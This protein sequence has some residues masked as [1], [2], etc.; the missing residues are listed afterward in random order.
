MRG[1]KGTQL[2]VSQSI[3]ISITASEPATGRMEFAAEPGM[4]E[5]SAR[6]APLTQPAELVAAPPS[7]GVPSAL[8]PAVFR[9]AALTVLFSAAAAHEAWKLFSLTSPEIWVH[10]RTGLWI[11]ENRAVPHTGLFSRYSTLAWIDS[12]WLYDLRLGIAY[13]MFGLRAIP[14]SLI[15]VR[16]G[17]ALV[18][19]FV[20]RVGRA[21]FWNAVLL[22][23]VA[24]YVISELQPLPYVVSIIFFAIEL[25]WLMRT[26]QTGNAKR[27]LWLPLLFVLWANLHI[28]FVAGLI[29][30]G[31]FL[32]AL[33]VENGLR[34][35]HAGWISD[36]IVP[37]DLKRTAVIALL[38][39]LAT[40]VNP[41]GF[42]LIPSALKP[43]YS[44]VGF[45]HFA[46]MSAMHFRRPQDFVLM[47]LVMFAF[48]ALGR[49]RSVDVFA[50]IT[51]LAGA[52]LAFRIARDGWLVVLPAIAVLSDGFQL[53]PAPCSERSCFPRPQRIWVMALTAAAVV[54]AMVR[55]PGSY[56]LMSRISAKFPVKACEY[57]EANHLLQPLFNAY[58]WGSFVTWYLP[59]YPVAVDSRVELYG[60]DV[61]GAYFDV[62]TGKKLLESEPMVTSSGTLLLE[63]NF[64]LSKALT[65]LPTLR[66]RYRL[67]YSDEIAS[68][69]VPETQTQAETPQAVD[70]RLG[71]KT[72][73][74]SSR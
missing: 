11:L 5:A 48:L 4:L 21:G 61:L 53:K 46:E 8:A 47:L 38:S 68:V 50:W 9:I 55:V 20:A 58:D 60:S 56:Q 2:S 19:F 36:S 15:V 6:M 32:I 49:K 71:T 13:R 66:A 45:E 70:Y 14:L 31:F 59:Q 35:I 43:L 39:V 51:L 65:D 42:R 25:Q 64:A 1:G 30:L 10:L 26:R 62:V 24:Q 74:S 57:I 16:L 7:S 40:L 12:T 73:A 23:A 27:L 69:F 18:T 72:V 44:G 34:T 28:Q 29:L 3:V 67:V 17:V 37:L 63:K 41:Y 52:L 33:V 22:S 54:I